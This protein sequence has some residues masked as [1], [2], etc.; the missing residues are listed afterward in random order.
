[1]N[2]SI[3]LSSGDLDLAF[4]T[5]G[6]LPI[7]SNE[8]LGLPSQALIA[9]KDKKLLVGVGTDIGGHAKL[10]RLNE[11]GTRDRSYGQDGYAEIPMGTGRLPVK[12]VGAL[13]GGSVV[14]GVTRKD[15]TSI[16]E[17]SVVRHLEDGQLDSTFGKNGTVFINLQ[18]LLDPKNALG[19]EIVI[20]R[21]SL[22]AHDRL[23]DPAEILP[24]QQSDGKTLLACTYGTHD[25]SYK[26]I[27]IRLKL[28]GEL[29]ESFNGRGYVHVEVGTPKFKPQIV[30]AIAVQGD[31]KILAC[32]TNG[33]EKSRGAFAVRY[34][35]DGQ[36]DTS[37]GGSGTGIL[38]VTNDEATLTFS[39]ME[40]LSASN[41]AGGIVLV[42]DRLVLPGQITDGII[43]V[44]TADGT[45]DKG[46]NGGSLLYT[47][48]FDFG[49]KWSTCGVQRDQSGNAVAI[50][51]S[52]PATTLEDDKFGMTI[53]A[54]YLLDGTLDTS[55]GAEGWVVYTEKPS[56][57]VRASVVTADNKIMLCSSHGSNANL[58]RY[59]A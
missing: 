53:T 28:N 19:I 52:G 46:F 5:G 54:R 7:P 57:V 11:D 30:N 34:T 16:R 39:A 50:I 36:I 12:L 51:V 10:A 35:E 59:L 22:T 14:V 44:L 37:F 38:P 15:P 32:G 13:N 40:L 42:G 2:Q 1:M 47:T 31:G 43:V 18:E 48:L 45:F 17:F 4:A 8:L 55:F 29:D 24:A 6:L 58:R 26:S 41:T 9:L 20:D 27:L 56:A 21:E 23:I 49:E 33:T 3:T 25:T